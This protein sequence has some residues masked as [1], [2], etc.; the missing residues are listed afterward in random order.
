MI[1]ANIS[2]CYTADATCRYR[3]CNYEGGPCTELTKYCYIK[4]WGGALRRIVKGCYSYDL[5]LAE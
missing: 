2:V 3:V 1:L 5:D 4:E